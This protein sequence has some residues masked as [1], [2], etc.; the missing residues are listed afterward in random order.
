[1]RIDAA[2]KWFIA[3]IV[4]AT[5]L[6]TSFCASLCT[7]ANAQQLDQKISQQFD[8]KLY[9]E[10]RWRCIGPFR[11]GRT[12]AISGLPHQPMFSTWL[13]LTA[14]SGRPPI[15]EIPG[16][17]YSTTSPAARSAHWPLPLPIRTSFTLAAA[18]D[19]SARILRPATASTNPPTRENPG[20]I[21]KTC[22]TRSKSQP[23]SSTRRIPTAFSS[24]PRDILMDPTSS[25]C[26][27]LHR[28]GTIVPESSLQ[29]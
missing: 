18:K 14:A 25:A 21:C 26:F 19:C 6:G 4:A 2:G 3:G 22:A 16:I 7:S 27:S 10:M 28:R 15:S 12:V 20:H 29:R 8:Q 13:P 5:I 24:P 9:S 17:R 1:M 23:S 11:G